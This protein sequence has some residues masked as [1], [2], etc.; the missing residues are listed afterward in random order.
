MSVLMKVSFSFL[1]LNSKIILKLLI[2]VSRIDL[3]LGFSYSIVLFIA[4]IILIATLELTLVI[5]L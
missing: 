3:V 2:V 5:T 4:P 1:S